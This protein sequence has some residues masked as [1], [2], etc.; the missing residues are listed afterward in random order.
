MTSQRKSDI[1]KKINAE[2]III[3]ENVYFDEGVYISG[4]DGPAAE[5]TIGDNVYVGKNTTF[6]LPKLRI[7]DYTKMYGNSLISG[8]KKCEIG[9]N[10]WIDRNCILNATDEL[11]LGNNVGIGAYSQLWTHIAFGDLLEGCRFNQTKKMII[12]DDV[13]FVGHCLVSPIVAEKKSMAMLGSVITKDMKENHIYAGVPA[14]DLTE[15]IGTQFRV[16]SNED[17]III[18]ER[19]K[20]TFINNNPDIN[21]AK[22]QVVSEDISEDNGVT[23]FNVVNRTYNKQSSKEEVLFM[24]HLLPIYKFIPRNLSEIG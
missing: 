13:W 19:E 14:K 2:K 21:G 15:K 12:H 24:K 22:I 6:H 20:A 4:I 3:G 11:I 8:Y 23:Y 16:I 10:C 18:L 17:K 1:E 5:V 7:N 9:Y